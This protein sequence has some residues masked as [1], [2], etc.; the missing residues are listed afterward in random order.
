MSSTLFLELAHSIEIHNMPSMNKNLDRHRFDVTEY[1]CR[2][3][4]TSFM[5]FMRLPPAELLQT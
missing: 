5:A 4:N 3:V 2:I 1:L